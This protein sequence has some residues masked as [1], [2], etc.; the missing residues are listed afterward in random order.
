MALGRDLTRR[1]YPRYAL[2]GPIRA[3]LYCSE[4]SSM[5]VR[6]RCCEVGE[7][8]AGVSLNDQLPVGEVVALELSPGLRVYAA[9]RYLRG[10]YH[11]FE[12]VML[13]DRQREAIHQLCESLASRH[14]PATN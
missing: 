1:R 2:R 6:G 11:G 7:G 5:I 13:R 4:T 8:G 9:V 10:F 14:Q 12:F 3:D